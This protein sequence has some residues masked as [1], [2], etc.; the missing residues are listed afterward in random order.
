MS[1][2]S[3]TSETVNDFGSSTRTVSSCHLREMVWKLD[4]AVDAGR[5]SPLRD[6]VAS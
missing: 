5:G 4:G 3:G 1:G 6:T 2:S